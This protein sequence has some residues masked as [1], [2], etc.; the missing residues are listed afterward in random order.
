MNKNHYNCIYMYINKINNKKY[1]GQT[2]DF[3]DRH[4]RHIQSSFNKNAKRDYNTPFHRAIRKYGIENFDIKILAENIPTQEK[5]N[6]YEV[7]FIKRYKT[8]NIQDGYN[9]A[10]GGYNNPFAGK[11]EEEMEEFKRKMSEARKG[12]MIGENN[13][14]YGKQHSQ[15]TK[16]KISKNHAN[17]SGKNNPNYGKHISENQ[18]E[19][20][21]Q[22]NTGKIKSKE[23]KNKISSAMKGKNNP[24]A[25]MVIQYDKQGKIIKIWDYAKQAGEE[26]G[27]NTNG[28]TKCCRGEGKSAGGFCWKY[29]N[30][31]TDDDLKRY[32]IKNKYFSI[33]V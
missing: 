18:K 7:F 32:I 20:L 8:L 28:I 15:E 1:V 19:K 30:N 14:F 23:T 13:P 4:R 25:K 33:N 10:E 24:K 11:T 3:F 29:L 26:L 6:E 9:V 2:K 12:Q 21:R 17:V 22:I 31:I 27:I 16:N 5:V